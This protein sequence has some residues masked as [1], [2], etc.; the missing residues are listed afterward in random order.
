M[1]IHRNARLFGV[2]LVGILGLIFLMAITGEIV[3]VLSTI[4]IMLFLFILG[5]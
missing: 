2:H 1:K 5:T 3:A 4:A